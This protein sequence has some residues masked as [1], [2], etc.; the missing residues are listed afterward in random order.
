[1]TY[2]QLIHTKGLHVGDVILGHAVHVSNTA[3]Y[4]APIGAHVLTLVWRPS[5][6]YVNWQNEVSY[7]GLQPHP[8]HK[9]PHFL[10]N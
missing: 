5:S 6:F 10:Y 3:V 9:A 2:P 7:Q 4:T 8:K 1:M